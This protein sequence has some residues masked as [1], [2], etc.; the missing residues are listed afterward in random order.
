MYLVF[1]KIYFWYNV[2]LFLN[3]QTTLFIVIFVLIHV[4][5]HLYI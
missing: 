5:V 3:N 2:F 4:D 1:F